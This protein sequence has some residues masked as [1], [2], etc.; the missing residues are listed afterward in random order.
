MPRVISFVIPSMRDRRADLVKCLAALARE[1]QALPSEALV[2]VEDDAAAAGLAALGGGTLA[3]KPVLQP[4]GAAKRRNAAFRAL[5]GRV[6]ALI[7]DDAEP[8]PG[9]GSA[10]AARFADGSDR[11]VQ[12]AVW[13][14]FDAEPPAELA[15]VLFS[16]GGF[17]RHGDERRPEVFISA[18]C[19]FTRSVL[20]RA[21]P[22]REDM[23]PGSGGVPWGDDT[24]W[25][26]RA[27]RLGV[28][29][30]FDEGIAVRHRIQADR[31]GVDAVLRRAERVGR[32]RARLEWDGKNP[33]FGALLRQR[34][35]AAWAR[36]KGA[37]IEARCRARR[38]AGYADEL[39]RMRI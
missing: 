12:G 10:L 32:T 36:T 16:I 1:T 23:G 22:M 11:I 8:M 17:N 38:L 31:I 24:E 26:A 20:E 18:N 9:Y 14:A 5:T 30:E 37:S 3:V 4:G 29:T 13:P 39:A 35:L 25:H 28:P 7:D 6:V 2:V 15:P 27:S 19:A 33:G 21:G 34:A